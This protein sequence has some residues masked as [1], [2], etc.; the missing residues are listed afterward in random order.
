MKPKVIQAFDRFSRWTAWAMGHPVAFIAALFGIIIWAVSGPIFHFSDTW[1]LV[2]NTA[3]SV[4]TFLMVFL[5][6]NAVNRDSVAVQ[7]KL[8][9]LIRA[10]EGARNSMLRIEDLSEEDLAQL[11]AYFDHLVSRDTPPPPAPEA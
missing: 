2:V 11:R 4:L 1:Q 10:L 7:L 5:I 3:T 6:Q 9:E 8:D